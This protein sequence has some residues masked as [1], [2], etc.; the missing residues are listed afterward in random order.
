MSSSYDHTNISSTSFTER[1]WKH[2]V[3]DQPT[4]IVYGVYPFLA[5]WLTYWIF[6]APFI[7]YQFLKVRENTCS[8]LSKRYISWMDKFLINP[9]HSPLDPTF[10]WKILIFCSKIHFFMSLPMTILN[11]SV[12]ATIHE[13]SYESLMAD[14]GWYWIPKIIIYWSIFMAMDEVLFFG[15]HYL[16]HKV[17]FLYKHVHSLHH[18]L[19]YTVSVGCVYAHPVEYLFGNVIPVLS[20]PSLLRVHLFWYCLWIVFKMME[21]SYVHSGFDFKLNPFKWLTNEHAYHH[22]HYQDNYGTWYGVMDRIFRT[23]IHFEEHSEKKKQAKKD[24]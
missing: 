20:G 22:S 9:S 11:S 24:Q 15:S 10:Y 12:M 23:S 17:P 6:N 8:T 14:F 2:A 13:S 7:A 18:E 16:L 3:E 21:T 1:F 4:W 5:Q 19:R